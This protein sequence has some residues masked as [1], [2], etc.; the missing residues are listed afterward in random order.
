M[1]ALETRRLFSLHWELKLLLYLGV[2]LLCGGLG[3]LAILKES[4][5]ADDRLI[6]T[7]ILLGLV[8][9]AAGR[10]STQWRSKAHF[11]LTYTNFGIHL[12]FIA[13]LAGLFTHDGMY[14]LWFVL[15]LA[16]AHSNMLF[17]GLSYFIFSSIAVGYLL[18]S[19]H[20]KLK[21]HDSL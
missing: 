19:L 5:F 3:V 8:L 6:Y 17:I 7:G 14:G 15:L 21:T 13:A 11:E 18:I 10:L 12:F 1:E 9:L 4:N 16:R 20:K 2:T